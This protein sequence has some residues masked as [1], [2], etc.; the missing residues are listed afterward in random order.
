[1]RYA[2]I[3]VLLAACGPRV[4]VASRTPAH[5][6]CAGHDS[7][8]RGEP[9]DYALAGGAEI[10]GARVAAPE[11]CGEG[12]SAYVAL[13]REAG[14]RSLATER[15]AGGGFSM[16]CMELPGDP[17]SDACPAINPA[18]ILGEAQRVLGE[19]GIL[20]NGMGLGPCGDPSGDY[21]A[22]RFSLGVVSWADLEAAARAV[23]D[24]MARYDVAGTIGVAVR[25]IACV[26]L[27]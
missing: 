25:G 13:S 19:A 8:P 7:T 17:A 14:R 15:A 23:I 22:W 12:E 3:I 27:L 16:E 5:T 20:V 2:V 4:A 6:R 1:V 10:D 24:V 11:L 21:A 18:A 26:E 9:S